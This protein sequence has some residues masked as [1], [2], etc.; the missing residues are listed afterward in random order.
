[1][2]KLVSLFILVVVLTLTLSPSTR[3]NPDV[4]S[5]E[6]KIISLDVTYSCWDDAKRAGEYYPYYTDDYCGLLKF[7]RA[8]RVGDTDQFKVTYTSNY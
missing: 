2:K 5:Q 4:N 7:T 6:N 8:H 1:M 3:V